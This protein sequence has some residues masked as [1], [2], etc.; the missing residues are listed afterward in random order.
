[1]K[2]VSLASA[3]VAIGERDAA[4]RLGLLLEPAAEGVL[5]PRQLGQ[6]GAAVRPPQA[7][8]LREDREVAPGGHAGD[9]ERALDR[10]DG[11]A[12][13]LAEHGQDQ[14]PALLRDDRRGAFGRTLLEHRRPNLQ[15]VM[16]TEAR[17]P[18]PC[19]GRH[20][21]ATSRSHMFES[22]PL[23]PNTTVSDHRNDHSGATAPRRAP[24]WVGIARAATCSTRIVLGKEARPPS[25]RSAPA[26]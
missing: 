18:R 17:R 1:M 9:A 20:V 15:R 4:L 7:P 25:S 21:C 8:L 13:A 26:W 14:A 22:T 12:A 5:V 16:D 23:A 11:H 10:G 24:R 3:L 19:T 6:H 2:I